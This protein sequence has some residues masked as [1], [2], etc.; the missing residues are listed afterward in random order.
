[1]LIIIIETIILIY[2]TINTLYYFTQRVQK[3]K[4]T[5]E[6]RE[7]HF[8]ATWWSM[9]GILTITEKLTLINYLP[10]YSIMKMGLLGAL[11][12]DEYQKLI[13]QK[14]SEGTFHI[15]NFIGESKIYK[16]SKQKLNSMIW[17]NDK[18]ASET[19]S[20]GFFNFFG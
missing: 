2:P 20:K 3:E 11:C 9:Y 14:I 13:L 10:L 6:P 4:T 18:A 16:D 8:I 5:Y 15:T 19:E 1:M 7:V 17:K 12:F